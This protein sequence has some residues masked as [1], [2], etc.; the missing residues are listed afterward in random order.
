MIQINGKGEPKQTFLNSREDI[1]W[2]KETHLP[3]NAPKFKCAVLFGNEDCPSRVILM[4]GK[5]YK[6]K[7]VAT[8][9]L[10]KETLKLFQI[11]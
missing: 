6:S 7:Q 1:K 11:S 2:L 4:A 10:D 9:D 8:Y 5:H 3:K